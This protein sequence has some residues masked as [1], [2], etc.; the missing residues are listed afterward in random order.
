MKPEYRFRTRF[1]AVVFRKR[2][3]NLQL[4]LWRR[5]SHLLLRKVEMY[6]YRDHGHISPL[7]P[8]RHR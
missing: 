3:L 1:A 6:T 5:G 2:S 4:W 8:Q 7:E